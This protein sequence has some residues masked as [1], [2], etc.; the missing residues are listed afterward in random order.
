MKRNREFVQ[1]VFYPDGFL[2]K[3][4]LLLLGN[5]QHQ[6]LSAVILLSTFDKVD[7]I[8]SFLILFST[9]S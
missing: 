2:K 4:G 9:D 3:I 1:L 8:S 5:V 7:V 6:F